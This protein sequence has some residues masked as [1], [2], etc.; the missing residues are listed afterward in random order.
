LAIVV[1][2]ACIK[3]ASITVAVIIGRLTT[4]LLSAVLAISDSEDRG[5]IAPQ[6]GER[7]PVAGLDRDPDAHA[8]AQHNPVRE[9]AEGKANRYALH[10][11]DPV[12]GGILRGNRANTDPLAGASVVTLPA[13][14]VSI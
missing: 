8:G 3:V 13:R 5:D 2:S 6:L 14:G 9:L 4:P 10:D 7:S 11:L 1:S 12:A